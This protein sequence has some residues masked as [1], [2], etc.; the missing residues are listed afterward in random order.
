MRRRR[1]SVPLVPLLAVLALPPLAAQEAGS[2]VRSSWSYTGELGP[3]HWASLYAEWAACGNGT[4]QSP[5]DLGGATTNDLPGPEPWYRRMAARFIA[6]RQF[7]E[8]ER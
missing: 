7:P 3:E 4:R 1:S 5:I 6:S 8:N 2:A